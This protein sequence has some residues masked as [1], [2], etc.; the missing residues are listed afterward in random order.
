[1][2]GLFRYNS[3]ISGIIT[4][5]R[6]I[7]NRGRNILPGK[8]YTDTVPRVRNDKQAAGMILVLAL[9]PIE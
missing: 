6:R 9:L 8:L 2:C 3:A 4:D 1:V 7:V 5:I